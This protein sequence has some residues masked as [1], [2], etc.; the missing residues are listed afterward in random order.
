MSWGRDQ[1]RKEGSTLD[2]EHEDDCVDNNNNNET[3]SHHPQVESRGRGGGG[4]GGPGPQKSVNGWIVFVTG[5]SVDADDDDLL[6]VFS[7]YGVVSKL[8]MN[9]DRQ[10]GTCKGYALVEYAQYTDA[11]DAI[12]ALHGKA[13]LGNE[14]GVDWAFVQPT[15]ANRGRRARR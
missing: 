10:T 12:N 7:E 11:Q 2:K 15:T 14:I 5:V 6:D 8:T 3:S 9:R 4:G 1:R 13:I